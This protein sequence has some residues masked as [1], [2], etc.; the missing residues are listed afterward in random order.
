MGVLINYKSCALVLMPWD[1]HKVRNCPVTLEQWLQGGTAEGR[2]EEHTS[3]GSIKTL[4]GRLP[5]AVDNVSNLCG[6]LSR[7]AMRKAAAS[8]HR[9]WEGH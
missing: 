2:T 3:R 8:W 6:E 4:A 1:R 7:V 5:D 9:A